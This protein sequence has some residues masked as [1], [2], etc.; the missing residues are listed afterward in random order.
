MYPLYDLLLIGSFAL[1]YLQDYSVPNLVDEGHQLRHYLFF[2][3]E[4]SG[5]SLDTKLV[6]TEQVLIKGLFDFAVH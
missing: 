5:K 4:I 6:D 3:R 2:V 1:N